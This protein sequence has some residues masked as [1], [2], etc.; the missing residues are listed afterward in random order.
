MMGIKPCSQLLELYPP[1]Y[2]LP[3]FF[4]TLAVQA[5]VSHSYIYFNNES[6]L[7]LPGETIVGETYTERDIAR[8]RN[9]CPS[10]D[11]LQNVL[12]ILVKDWQK[13]C[14][15]LGGE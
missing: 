10:V 12:D 3:H 9:L 13:C 6:R 5:G 7:V 4:G 11:F 1:N 2:A 15:D 8:S 14:H